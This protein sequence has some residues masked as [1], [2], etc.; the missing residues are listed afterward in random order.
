MELYFSPLACSLATRIAFYEAGYEATYRQVD[1]KRKRLQD[2]TDFYEVNPL[3]QVPVLRTDDGE[4]LFEN[5]AILPYVADRFPS[6]NLAP[7][8]GLERA[9]L[10]QWLGFIGTELH[11]A[12]FVPVLDPSANEDV[13]RYAREDIPLRMQRLQT[14]L[15]TREWLL[16]AF[17]VADIYLAVVLN[18]ARYCEVDL[19]PWPAVLAFFKRMSLRPATA[20]AFAEEFELYGLEL[21]RA[22]T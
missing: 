14:H 4:L 16:D 18:W 13:K 9:R 12:V 3:G 6:A 2:G 10:H 1:T 19:S 17:S 22:N 15:A 8:G 21:K 7:S 20:R 5:A 11:K